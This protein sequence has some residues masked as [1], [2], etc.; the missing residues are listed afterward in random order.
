MFFA[1]SVAP[2]ILYGCSAVLVLLGFRR[3][4]LGSTLKGVIDI[5]GAGAIAIMGWSLGNP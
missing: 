2:F 1:H 3:I 5:V 4:R